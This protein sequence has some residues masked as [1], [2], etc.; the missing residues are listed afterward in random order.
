MKRT[1][2]T[3]NSQCSRS[4]AHSFPSALVLL[5]LGGTRDAR[6]RLSWDD[7]IWC[8]STWRRSGAQVGGFFATE[9]SAAA[10]HQDSVAKAAE[11]DQAPPVWLLDELPLLDADLLSAPDD[12]LRV[13]FEAFRLVVRY[14]QPGHHATVQVTIAGNTGAHLDPNMVCLAPK[15]NA[16]QQPVSPVTTGSHLRR[17]HP[18]RD[19]NPCRR[20]ER[21][22]SLSARRWGLDHPV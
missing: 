7:L 3:S 18:Q 1:E 11:V 14:D 17:S 4:L 2:V 21:A 10:P 13:I 15:I 20:L 8:L 9:V 19:S 6:S 12:K 22:V 5:G 16:Q